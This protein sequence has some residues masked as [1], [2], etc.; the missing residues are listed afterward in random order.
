MKNQI[1]TVREF[2]PKKFSAKVRVS[3]K[4]MSGVGHPT[5][6]TVYISV[7]SNIGNALAHC[8][9]GIS[10]I[11][12]IPG[13]QLDKTSTFY[14]TEPVDYTDQKWFVNAVVKIRTSLEPIQL[15]NLLKSI[16]KEEGRTENGIRFGPRVL[17]LDILFF[18]DLILDTPDLTIPHTRM[19]NRRFVLKPLCDINPDFVH[20]VLN[21]NMRNLLENSGKKGQRIIKLK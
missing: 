13:V 11:Q 4:N 17:D 6:H 8:L 14:K 1:D 20:P 16:E 2:P 9:K 19:Q 21:E 10:K 7:G 15:F 18:D 5:M 3:D 12:K